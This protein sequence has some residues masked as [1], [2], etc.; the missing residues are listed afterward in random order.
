MK[1]STQILLAFFVV[2]ILSVADTYIN[3]RL[4]LKVEK[5]IE[6]LSKSEAIIRNSNKIHQSIIQMQSAFRGYLLTDDTSFLDLYYEGLKVVPGYFTEQRDLIK[7]N[8]KQSTIL[9]SIQTLHQQWIGY[10]GSLIDSRT[11]SSRSSSSDSPY[12]ELLKNTLKAQIGKKLND[13]IATKFNEFDKREYIIRNTHNSKLIASISQTHTFSFIFITLT[14]VI[15]VASAIFIVILISKRIISMVNLAKNISNGQFTVVNDTRN[16]E[17]TGLSRSLNIMSDRLSKNIRDLENRNAELNKFAYV[18]SHDLKAPVRGIHNLI[19]WI[20]EDLGHELTPEMKKYLDMIPQ[21]TKRMEDL[22]NGLLEY[23]RISQRTNVSEIDVNKLVRDIADSIVPRH[24]KVEIDHLPHLYAERLKLEQ[25]F[26]NLISNSVKYTA[27]S[28]GHIIVSC[29]EHSEF[30]RFSVRDNGIGVDPEYHEKIFEIFQTLR[31]KNEIESTGVG[32]A[33][34]KKIIED[35]HGAI[36]LI[37]K[38]GEGAEFIFT[39]KKNGHI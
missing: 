6:F 25:V 15:G 39:W 7:E 34:V 32:L 24:F 28:N 12:N 10:A 36:K 26:S 33:I 8:E 27:P 20:E 37:S 38:S 11:K 31:D 4:S 14:I 5:N 2:V 19:K 22:I 18:V 35:Q 29:E 23:A 17:L 16:D 30:Y 13:A 9:D 1:L 21:R 3:Y